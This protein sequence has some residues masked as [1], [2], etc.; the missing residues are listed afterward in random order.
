MEVLKI[1]EGQRVSIDKQTPNMTEQ[2]IRQCQVLP[3]N[4]PEQI[5]RQQVAAMAQNANPFFRSHG[6]K[7]E[8]ELIRSDAQLLH[9]PALEYSNNDKV[10]PEP[11]RGCEFGLKKGRNFSI[12]RRLMIAKN[13]VSNWRMVGRDVNPR[14]GFIEA[15]AYPKTWVVA[16]VQGCVPMDA[17]QRFC[18]LFVE[19][20]VSRGLR[21][22]ALPP[23]VDQF[24]QT[25]MLV[26]FF[27]TLY[28]N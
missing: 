26:A 27:P 8:A 22:C 20:A 7:I 9:L 16:I 5:N 12:L 19:T 6:V 14:R 11:N 2:M 17:C 23:R 21:D 25:D 3:F 10:E 15:A 24:E 1:V 13:S 18:R 4:L 28:V